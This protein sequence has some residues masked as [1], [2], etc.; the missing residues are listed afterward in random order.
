MFDHADIK[1][2]R[3]DSESRQGWRVS[4]L[5]QK[6]E[7]QPRFLSC[8]KQSLLKKCN[9]WLDG[10]GYYMLFAYEVCPL[11]VRK[12]CPAGVS[13]LPFDILRKLFRNK[14]FSYS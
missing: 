5:M 2:K 12:R 9:R 11:V 10:S 8:I 13:S 6:S 1:K 4:K 7:S 14:G 3:L